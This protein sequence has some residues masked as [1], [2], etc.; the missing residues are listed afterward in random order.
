MSTDN[1]SLSTS[2]LAHNNLD[3]GVGARHLEQGLGEV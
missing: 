3:V 2:K 1:S